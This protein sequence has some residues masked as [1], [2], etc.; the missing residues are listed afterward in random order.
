MDNVSVK[1]IELDDQDC[2]SYDRSYQEDEVTVM[3]KDLH[4]DSYKCKI[5]L[6]DDR[7]FSVTFRKH[8]FCTVGKCCMCRVNNT[9][10]RSLYGLHKPTVPF[11]DINIVFLFPFI[12]GFLNYISY[13][14]TFP[15]KPDN[16]NVLIISY[17]D[18]KGT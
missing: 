13:F 11:V 3:I 4:D 8:V 18:V 15:A 17:E 2:S 5:F 9:H 7:I 14:F 12:I 6:S 10:I 16:F 1:R